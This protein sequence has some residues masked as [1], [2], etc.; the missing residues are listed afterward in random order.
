MDGNHNIEMETAIIKEEVD[1]VKK[2]MDDEA[3][4]EGEHRHCQVSKDD[5]IVMDKVCSILLKDGLKIY[6]EIKEKLE[7][8]C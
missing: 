6:N 1:V 7:H 3:W 2:M 4:Y 5:S 8:K